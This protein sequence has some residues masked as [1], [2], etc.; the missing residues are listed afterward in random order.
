MS[1]KTARLLFEQPW[2]E[3]SRRPRHLTL[4]PLGLGVCAGLAGILVS[5]LQTKFAAATAIAIMGGLLWLCLPQRLKRLS[6]I[7][8]CVAGGSMKI[9][10]TF[11]V[12]EIARGQFVPFAGGD[13]GITITASF[14]AAIIILWIL[15]TERGIG[16]LRA[17]VLLVSGPL[18]FIAAGFLSLINA[19]DP[20]LTCF[21]I[22]RQTTLLVVLIAICNLSSEDARF[23]TRVLAVMVVLQAL[24][25]AVQVATDSN[26]GLSIFGEQ[27]IV[28]EQ[29]NFEAEARATGTVGHPNDLAALFEITGPLVLALFFSTRPRWEKAAY[30]LAFTAAMGGMLLTLSRAAWMTLP[31][32]IPVVLIGM[33]GRRLLQPRAIAWS[34]ILL[35]PLGGGTALVALPLIAKRLFSDDAGSAS[36]RW[37]LIQ[38]AFSV[39]SQF[40]AFGVGLNN[41]GNAFPRYDATHNSRIFGPINHVVHNM[42]MLVWAEVGS[43]GLAAFLWS[44]IGPLLAAGR[45]FLRPNDAFTK[46]VAIGAGAGLFAHMFH[47]LFDPGFKINLT[48]STMMACNIGLIGSA[49]LNSQG[50]RPSEARAT[51]RNLGSGTKLP[52]H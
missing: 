29:I 27:T 43:V 2:G 44:L 16:E 41:L 17:P 19:G 38:A 32:T 35:L 24:L 52:G 40:P 10:K 51:F 6:A 18:M 22:L 4:G 28:Q 26:L 1:Q 5:N 13:A 34:F 42:Y 3:P 37:P 14:L 7:A 25:A 8:L 46:A 49:Y 31:I 47:G 48:L 15:C 39:V 9:S 30:L 20:A 21:E 23:A 11:F 12:H 36:T 45:A 50:S 33:C